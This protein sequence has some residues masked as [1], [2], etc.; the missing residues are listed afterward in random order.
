ME[1]I[2]AD[3]EGKPVHVAEKRRFFGRGSLL[4]PVQAIA[5]D[6]ERRTVVPR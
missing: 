4:I 6:D 5:L 2:Y 3:G 1:R